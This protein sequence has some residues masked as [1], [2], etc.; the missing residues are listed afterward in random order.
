MSKFTVEITGIPNFSGLLKELDLQQIFEQ[1]MLAVR[2]RIITDLLAGKTAEGG[3]LKPYSRSYI[4]QID[5]G[6][7]PG[8]APGSHTPNLLATGELHRS[9]TIETAENEV[10]MFF[11]GSHAPREKVSEKHAEKKRKNAVKKNNG[12][13]LQTKHNRPV[14][15]AKARSGGRFVKALGTKKRGEANQ[16]AKLNAALG[17]GKRKLSHADKHRGHGGGDV[18]NAVIAQGQYDRGRTGWFTLSQ[19]DIDRLVTRIND[20]IAKIFS[21]IAK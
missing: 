6:S 3:A 5:S 18:Q 2:A 21:R 13:V 4:E 10:S 20:A 19:K 7:I 1:E 16:Q 8:K 9:M 14:N 11:T 15:P 17:I 12:L